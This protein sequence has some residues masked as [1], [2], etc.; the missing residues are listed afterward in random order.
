MRPAAIGSPNGVPGPAA[1][2][3]AHRPSVRQLVVAR[4]GQAQTWARTTVVG[5]PASAHS[6]SARQIAARP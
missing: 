5:C 4:P 6:A 1:T 2:A 3:V